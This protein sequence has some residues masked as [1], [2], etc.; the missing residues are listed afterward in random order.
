MPEKLLSRKKRIQREAAAIDNGKVLKNSLLIILSFLF[1]A[2]IA[3]IAYGANGIYPFGGKTILISDMEG[4][5][6]DFYCRLY[7]ILKN[8]GSLFYSWQCGMGHN[9]TGLFAYYL[10]SPFSFLILFFKLKNLPDALYFIY[11]F[12]IGASGVTFF[13]YIKKLDERL[14]DALYI[15]FSS[16]YALM[17][18]CI[19]YSFNIM[20]LD[21]IVF[22][23]LVLLGV[24]GI[25]RHN[26]YILFTISLSITF[27]SNFYIS[28]M[29]GLFSFLYFIAS[30]YSAYGFQKKVFIRKLKIFMLSA[31]LSAGCAAFL[32]VPAFFALKNGVGM[33]KI[34]ILDFGIN[35]KSFALPGKLT[36]G[37]YDTLTL[38]SPN[39]YCGLL[40]LIASPL[41]F[42]NRKIKAREKAA[43]SI[44]L[45]F[46]ILCFVFSIFDLMWHCFQHPHWFP[47]RYSFLF[48]FLLISIS[49]KCFN[50]IDSL[51]RKIIPIVCAIWIVILV[52]VRILHHDYL[53]H[54]LFI[55]NVVF[56]IIYSIL[57]F[58]IASL[59]NKRS[60]AV[61]ALVFFALFESFLNAGYMIY[62]LD[63]EFGYA[64][65][66]K[67]D[68]A[69][70]PLNNLVTRIEERDRGFYRIDRDSGVGRSFNDSMNLNYR[71]ITHFSSMINGRLNNFLGSLGF[72][73]PVAQASDHTGATVVT[74]SFFGVKYII[75][76]RSRGF[77]YRQILGESNCKVYENLYALPIGFVVDRGLLNLTER[78]ANPFELQNELLNL[79]IGNGQKDYIDY[80]SP[81]TVETVKLNNA[82][83][84][85]SGKIRE[86]RKVDKN[87]PAS[88][89]FTIPNS[90]DQ[91]VYCYLPKLY[92][93]TVDVYVN[94]YFLESYMHFYNNAVLDI[95]YHHKDE[96]MRVK[97]VL[98][99]DSFAV[100]GEYFYGLDGAA[101]DGAIKKLQPG[102]F[103]A[104]QSG[105][106]FLR[107]SVNAEYSGLLFTSIPYDNG[108]SVTVDGK[109]ESVKKIAGAF[110]GVEI[111]EGE[112]E[113]AFKF[114]PQG[115]I[116][117]TVISCLSLIILS[118]L[119]MKRYYS[120]EV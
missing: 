18:Y 116:P 48:S 85:S 101:F 50:E 21:G 49:V 15:M 105:D 120:H 54:N 55:I 74:D 45:I 57:L 102:G 30:Y 8:N 111:P 94:G 44:L 87:K 93:S 31:L 53:Q 82:T 117:G 51:N 9:F 78:N 28:Y 1:P 68:K 10:A 27:I 37:A 98:K 36:V 83:G 41:F 42:A 6:I 112:H 69:L 109:T 3:G 11:L 84:H 95:G 107:G 25:I 47:F 108:W 26:K 104:L 39:I 5:Y 59:H 118:A 35:I 14:P 16:L 61:I 92:Y 76:S 60:V 119:T 38:G 113:V 17:S 2:M 80:F 34:S 96:K 115:F 20:W 90:R 23:P 12:K 97:L 33:Q 110:I 19:V 89:E 114:L 32:M 29:V 72:M 79:S 75:S 66:E 40:T 22:L 56:L 58:I 71:G 63:R 103:R 81:L 43:Y 88:V 99:E 52:L 24:E 106:T 65:R 73:V 67:Y 91:Q 70:E 4:Q 77:G 46:F 7:D 13:V 86:F 64:S 62:H 100:T